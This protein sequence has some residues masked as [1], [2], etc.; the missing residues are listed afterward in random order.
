MES[1]DVKKIRLNSGTTYNIKDSR[2]PALTNDTTTFL[3]SD[4]T[5]SDPTAN[6]PETTDVVDN[7]TYMTIYIH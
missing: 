4:G 6:L 1:V 7:G 2:I 3:R 5:W